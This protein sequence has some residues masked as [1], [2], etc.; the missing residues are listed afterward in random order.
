MKR[1]ILASAAILL[2]LPTLMFAR[3]E[4]QFDRTLTVSGAV[5]LDLT[6]GSGEVM[7]KTGSGNRS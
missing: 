3:V 4:G 2:L 1:H 7:I 5:N 6:T